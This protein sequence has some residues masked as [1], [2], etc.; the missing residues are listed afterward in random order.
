M[1]V[2][3][4]KGKDFT[5]TLAF[6]PTIEDQFVIVINDTRPLQEIVTDFTDLTSIEYNDDVVDTENVNTTHL[7]LTAVKLHQNG[8]VLLTFNR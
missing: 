8:S 2:K 7:R 5:A 4:S 3:T 1:K 6:G